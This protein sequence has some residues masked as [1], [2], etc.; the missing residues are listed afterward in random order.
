MTIY[1][2]AIGRRWRKPCLS[3][4][5]PWIR[6]KLNEIDFGWS[7]NELNKPR[8]FRVPAGPVR[9]LPSPELIY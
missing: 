4:V 8:R 1:P 7:R 3:I 6:L 5:T 2:Y 9:Q